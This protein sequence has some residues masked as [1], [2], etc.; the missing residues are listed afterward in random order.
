MRYCQGCGQ[1]T[2]RC[3]G[4]CG[5]TDHFCAECGRR[6]RTIVVFPGATAASCPA[7]GVQPAESGEFAESAES[8]P[9]NRQR[10]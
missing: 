9:Q 5:R 4:A 10:E 3:D 6:L 2:D 1:A 8:A 7:H